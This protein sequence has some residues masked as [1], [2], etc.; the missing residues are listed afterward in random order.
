M[1]T[2]TKYTE[3]NYSTQTDV[4]MRWGGLLEN[5]YISKFQRSCLDGFKITGL[6]RVLKSYEFESILDVGCGLG[7]YSRIRK[8][9]YVGLDNSFAR[10]VFAQN[11]YKKLSFLQSDAVYL[12]FKD[13]SFEAI[14][15]ANTV[16]HLS[17]D[18]FMSVLDQMQRVSRKYII[19]D[20]CVHTPNQSRLSKF[21]YSLDRGAA[22]RRVDEFKKVFKNCPGLK[23]VSE[24][25][26]CT[27]PGLY[28]HAVFILEAVK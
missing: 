19:I 5:P 15:L 24:Q 14:L 20:D 2:T 17:D 13:N 10:V 26:H 21:F 4:K 22:F 1:T 11:W 3:R 6:A 12:P 8:G 16:H 18:E 9:R 23:L 27:F 7:E 25:K 28:C